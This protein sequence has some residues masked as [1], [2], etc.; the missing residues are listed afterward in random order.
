MNEVAPHLVT[1]VAE[2][3]R[4][5]EIWRAAPVLG[6][7]TEFV[8]TRTFHARL[9][10]VQVAD[11]EGVYLIDTVAIEDLDVL[12]ELLDAHEG[13]HVFHSCSED[14]GIFLHRF[15]RAPRGLFDTQVAAALVGLGFSISYQALVE[16][17]LGVVV[18][19]EH[20]R[21][22]WMARPLSA[23]QLEYAALDV[24]HLDALYVHL[25]DRLR[26]LGRESW[27]D[28]EHSRLLDPSRYRVEPEEA[29]RRV[30]GGGNLDRRGLGLLLGL[31]AWREEEAARVDRARGFV[32]RDDALLAIARHRPTQM[33][34]LRRLEAVA[35]HEARRHGRRLLQIVRAGLELPESELPA[36]APRAPRVRGGV[37]LVKELQ[38]LVAQ[39]AR[40]LEVPPE[41]LTQRRVLEKVVRDFA[42]SGVR[43]LPAEL[44][45]WRREV[46]GKPVLEYLDRKI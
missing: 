20:T 15:G 45:G 17:V 22:N 8:R 11:H 34:E 28:E 39:I 19:K 42:G 14:V 33:H 5:C 25:R 10:L 7:D 13:R 44:E 40:E 27:L 35:P 36:R 21:S 4:L 29:Y 24:V 2:L 43:T 1:E 41:V 30:K 23:G 18:A 46:V 32:V 38:S 12:G 9:G 37:E 26:E 6:I 3:A 31:C 16:R